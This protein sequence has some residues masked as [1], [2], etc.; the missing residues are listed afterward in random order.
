MEAGDGGREAK[1]QGDHPPPGYL[2]PTPGRPQGCPCDSTDR[3]AK[4]CAVGVPI[5]VIKKPASA[6]SSSCL[7]FVWLCCIC[8]I[9]HCRGGRK[10]CVR[11]RRVVQNLKIS[12]L[13]FQMRIIQS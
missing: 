10:G 6:L 3:L 9:R 2:H 7:Y 1:N 4:F 5:V 13:P 12:P 8:I 11:L